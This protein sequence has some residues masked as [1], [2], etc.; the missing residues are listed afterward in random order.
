MSRKSERI[1]E[2]PKLDYKQLHEGTKFDIVEDS[3]NI[4]VSDD[5][6]VKSET[7]YHALDNE[8]SLAPPQWNDMKNDQKRKFTTDTKIEEKSSDS[9]EELEKLR[10]K[11]HLLKTT[12]K[13][14]LETQIKHMQKEIAE[15]DDFAD[16]DVYNKRG[17]AT[18]AINKT[19]GGISLSSEGA[20]GGYTHNTATETGARPKKPTLNHLRGMADLQEEVNEHLFTLGVP[21]FARQDTQHT[22][23][24]RHGRPNIDVSKHEIMSDN[25]D[26]FSRIEHTTSRQNIY[27]PN[28]HGHFS[29]DKDSHKY[30]TPGMNCNCKRCLFSLKITLSV[31]LS[32]IPD[33][34]C[35]GFVRIVHS[36]HLQS[37]LQCTGGAYLR[38]HYFHAEFPKS[39]QELQL[40]INALELLSITVACKI[41]GKH[42]RGNKILV[43]CD[44]TTSVTVLNSGRTKD[45]FLLKCLREICYIS[46]LCEFS[47][48]AKH[49]E[50]TYNRTADLLSRWKQTSNPLTKLKAM[51]NDQLIEHVIDNGIFQFS[52]NW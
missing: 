25:T 10:E 6:N 33:L 14:K 39:I 18:S 38:G 27:A 20:T 45:E 30:V 26:N 21:D 36:L 35:F 50:G 52:H 34:I 42:L 41:W 51:V 4:Y 31:T 44:N 9:D 49:I 12:L 2:K 47:V 46:S 40:H 8:T 7:D 16:S 43:F 11:K 15:C 37:C 48:K 23:K 5:A 17:D 13:L 3:E 1:T 19:L 24:K 28:Q 22:T 29:V 32:V